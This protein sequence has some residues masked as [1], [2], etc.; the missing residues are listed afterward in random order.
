MSNKEFESVHA[1]LAEIRRAVAANAA[2]TAE[3]VEMYHNIKGLMHV[4]GWVERASIWLAK[5][6]AAAALVYA[7]WRHYRS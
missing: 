4:L 2:S 5:I 3:L 1:E 6:G 7:A